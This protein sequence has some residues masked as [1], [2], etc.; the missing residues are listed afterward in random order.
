MYIQRAERLT[1][2]LIR[3]LIST[4][5]DKF[6]DGIVKDIYDTDLVDLHT[7]LFIAGCKNL[8]DGKQDC[9]VNR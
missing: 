8:R 4:H 7:T 1:Q 2:V 9:G 3:K 6:H 5:R